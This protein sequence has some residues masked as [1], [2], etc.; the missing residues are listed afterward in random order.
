MSPRPRARV[1]EEH[2]SGERLAWR[3]RGHGDKESLRG[4]KTDVRVAVRG[5]GASQKSRAT[6][7]VAR[8]DQ[9]RGTHEQHGRRAICDEFFIAGRSFVSL[10]YD[11]SR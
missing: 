1:E 9:G 3:R 7:R 4:L 8:A 6:N 2:G 5:P 10:S 11:D